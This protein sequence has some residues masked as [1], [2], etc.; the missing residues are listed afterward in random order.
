MAKINTQHT[1]G[2]WGKADST[3]WRVTYDKNGTSSSIA[4]GPR[5]STPTCFAVGYTPSLINTSRMEA[6]LIA[7]ADLIAAAPEL[8]EALIATSAVLAALGQTMGGA[9]EQARAAIA[10]ATGGAA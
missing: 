2:P 4:I 6:E 3:D 7:N 1:S 8:L 5:G 9:Y 10:R